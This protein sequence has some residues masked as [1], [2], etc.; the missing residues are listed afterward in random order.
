MEYFG[1][2]CVDKSFQVSDCKLKTPEA[3]PDMLDLPGPEK[4]DATGLERTC[5]LS[6]AET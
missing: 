6:T 4:L 1:R 2:E 3:L 5:P